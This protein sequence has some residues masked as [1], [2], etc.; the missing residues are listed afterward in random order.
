M[1]H[2]KMKLNLPR[3]TICGAEQLRTLKHAD[4]THV[5][6]IWGAQA[7]RIVITRMEV[8]FPTAKLHVAFF[9]DVIEG[10]METGALKLPM[11]PT[12]V[13]WQGLHTVVW[14]LFGR[15]AGARKSIGRPQSPLHATIWRGKSALLC[16]PDLL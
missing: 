4:F 3:I 8:M 11:L 14:S 7:P 15:C 5:V 6:S 10:T 2:S 12:D 13:A 1:K 9:D 16:T